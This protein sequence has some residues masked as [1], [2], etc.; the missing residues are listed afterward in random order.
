MKDKR[1]K[2]KIT[3]NQYNKLIKRID[4]VTG[5]HLK[6]N[7]FQ[8]ELNNMAVKVFTLE[9]ENKILKKD[10]DILKIKLRNS[11]K[12]IYKKDVMTSLF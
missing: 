4:K 11:P 3:I 10:I 12:K 7:F 8:K 9:K 5:V 1:F 6:I 2:P